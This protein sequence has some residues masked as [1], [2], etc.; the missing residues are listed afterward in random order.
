MKKI[1]NA[2]VGVF[3]Y[4]SIALFLI[5]VYFLAGKLSLYMAFFNESVSPLW[6]PTGVA[7]G[8]LLLLGCRFWPSI[9]LGAFLVNVTTTPSIPVSLGIALGN[10]LESLVGAYLLMRFAQG[11]S[12]FTTFKSTLSCFLIIFL[13]SIL[14]ATI[15]TI[16]LSLGGFAVHNQFAVFGTW[17]IGDFIGGIIILPLILAFYH[18]SENQL[19]KERYPEAIFIFFILYVLLSILFLGI[20]FQINKSYHLIYMILFPLLWIAFRFNFRAVMVSLFITTALSTYGMILG[21]SLFSIASLNFALI[22]LQIFLGLT[23]IALI[24]ISVTILRYKSL[25]SLAQLKIR[26]R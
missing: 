5:S 22:T 24:F 11:K 23:T 6:I 17:F 21:T 19:T 4:L 18:K 15:G 10:T 13:A 20:P 1:N 7:L 14:S 3:R 12:V 26:R 9:F 8:S 2:L 25:E 16:S